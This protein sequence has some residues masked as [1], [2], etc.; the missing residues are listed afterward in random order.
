MTSTVAVEDR[1]AVLARTQAT[2]MARS[3][4]AYVRG[5]TRSFYEW[6]AASPVASRIPDGPPVWI[7]GDCHIGNLGPVADAD[8]HVDVQIRDLDQTVIGNPAHDLIRLALS[9][10]TA[11]RGA[12]L[13]GVMTARMIEAMIE[14]YALALADPDDR[15]GAPEPQAVRTVREYAMG[16]RWRHLAR[17]RID[18][19][20]TQITL[21]RKFWPLSARER[22][23]IETLFARATIRRATLRLFGHERHGRL[24]MIDAAYWR[25]GCSSLGTLRYAVLVEVYGS[26]AG[27]KGGHLAL[28][29]IKQAVRSV[30]PAAT[31]AAMPRNRAERVVAGARA[32]S[33]NLGDRMIAARLLGTPVVLRELMPQD[34]K[35]EVDQFSRHEAV[36]A[37][38]Y[39]AFVVGVAH[40]QQMDTPTRAHWRAEL[41]HGH[42]GALDAPS[43]LW[44][45]VVDLAARH[46]AGYLDFCRTY[47]LGADGEAASTSD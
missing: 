2:K 44:E 12:D 41:Q 46:E 38:R 19:R 34:L 28:I 35:L 5:S 23:A 22:T 15:K 43:W 29:D 16:R 11:A 20:D 40:G 37:A 47:A 1:A 3:A 42:D 8:G 45:A 21:G 39:L 26:K 27:A 6:L 30:V 36:E 13:P 18:G 7:C 14:G 32:L 4:F 10:E 9:L 24:R 25:K 31:G 33:P 17:E